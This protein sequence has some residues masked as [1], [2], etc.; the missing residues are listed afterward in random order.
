[1]VLKLLERDSPTG[2]STVSESPQVSRSRALSSTDTDI[3]ELSSGDSDTDLSHIA[4]AY[5]ESM[6]LTFCPLTA[7]PPLHPPSLKVISSDA[8][9]SKSC[10]PLKKLRSKIVNQPIRRPASSLIP[11]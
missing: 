8:R 7:K 6:T 11:V 4:S 3:C 2:Y 10:K 9:S 5:D 1:M